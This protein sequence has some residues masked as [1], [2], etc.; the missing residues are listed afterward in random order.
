VPEEIALLPYKAKEKSWEQMKG[1][2][3]ARNQAIPNTASN[4]KSTVMRCHECFSEGL[5]LAVWQ[6]ISQERRK[7]LPH[8]HRLKRLC[9]SVVNRSITNACSDSCCIINIST[10]RSYEEP[11]HSFCLLPVGGYP[12]LLLSHRLDK[13]ST[14]VFFCNFLD[15]SEL[16]TRP[17]AEIPPFVG[18]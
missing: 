17:Q 12:L 6:D 7:K 8:P 9:R 11:L 14:C 1:V 10:H 15:A 3:H 2:G 16:R 5:A 13:N 4:A 18:N